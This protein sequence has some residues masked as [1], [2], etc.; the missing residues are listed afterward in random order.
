[1]PSNEAW[2]DMQV[3][4]DE[5]RDGVAALAEATAVM[6]APRPASRLHFPA[7]SAL[8]TLTAWVPAHGTPAHRLPA[9]SSVA[10]KCKRLHRLWNVHALQLSRFLVVWSVLTTRKQNSRGRAAASASG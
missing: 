5:A 2:E 7:L 8:D 3:C 9:A 1:M 10:S 4:S 6:C